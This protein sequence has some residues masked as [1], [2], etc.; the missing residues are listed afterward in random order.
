[1]TRSKADKAHGV[2][3]EQ[4]LAKANAVDGPP[5]GAACRGFC[6]AVA[7]ILDAVGSEDGRRLRRVL[8]KAD[9]AAQTE[10]GRLLVGGDFEGAAAELVR[11][12]RKKK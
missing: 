1:V 7:T 4:R 6:D 3:H 5:L 10:V 11:R 2:R 8:E 9:E 12:A